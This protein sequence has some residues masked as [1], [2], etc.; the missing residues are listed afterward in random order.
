MAENPAGG[1]VNPQG[2]VFGTENL[3]VAD[4][5]LFPTSGGSNPSLTIAACAMKIGAQFVQSADRV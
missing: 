5:S 4:A 3:Y 1:V 2:K